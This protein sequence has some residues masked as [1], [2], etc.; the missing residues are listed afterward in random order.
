M[1][2]HI[3][4]NTKNIQRWMRVRLE[5]RHSGSNDNF[6]EDA[7]RLGKALQRIPGPGFPLPTKADVYELPDP[8]DVEGLNKEVSNL[9]AHLNM[10]TAGGIIA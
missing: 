6:L 3:G 10:P 9:I 5:H 2:A 4:D 1:L 7:L 8:N